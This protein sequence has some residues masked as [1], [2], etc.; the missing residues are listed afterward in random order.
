MKDM[1]RF[2]IIVLI[3]CTLILLPCLPGLSSQCRA[4][5]TIDDEKKLGREFYEKLEKRGA[6]VKNRKVT[7]YLDEL[8]RSLTVQSTASPFEFTFSV[9]RDSGI[10]AFATPGG[11]VYVYSG[12]IEIAENESQL[13]GVLAHEIA[14]VK[15]RHIAKIIEK[16]QKV[17]IATLAA[18]LAGAFIGGGGEGSAA[19]AGFSLAT[20][21][22]LNLKY[23]REHEEEADY[24]G[25]DYLVKSGYD[26]RGMLDFLKIMRQYEYYSNSIPS[27]FLTHPG[28]SERIRYLDALL[29]TRYKKRGATALLSEFDR[30][31]T[32][33]TLKDDDFDSQMRYFEDRLKTRNDDIEGLYGIAMVEAKQ[34]KTKEALS[35]FNR[36]LNLSPNDPDILRDLGITHFNAGS[37]E[38]ALAPL[39]KAHAI[40]PDDM[41]TV[42]YL[43]RVSDAL[44][45]YTAALGFY[46]SYREKNPDSD[47]IYYNLAMTCGK[48][49]A[50]G[51]SHYNFGIFFKK[52]QKPKSALFHFEAALPHFPPDS[53]RA[54][55]ITKEVE[56]LRHG[57]GKGGH[58]PPGN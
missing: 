33:L 8:G 28:T 50:T 17:N 35:R 15:A 34:G 4:S 41:E 18:I 7:G 11:Y 48:M 44:G 55:E 54:A 5:F 36:V 20:A 29:Q 24:F 39:K 16:S 52:K 12:L 58:P 13:A 37:A 38:A 56:A 31:K 1:K 23:S 32:L 45:D 22:S 47:S 19:I 40:D 27:Y 3:L 30:V 10:N 9:I 46:Q 14:H 25:M 26:G 2:K 6:L 57:N 42:L 53:E 51:D 21:A 49:N 43:G